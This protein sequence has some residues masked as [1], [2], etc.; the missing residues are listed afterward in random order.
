V[1][2][3]VCHF[4]QGTAAF[5]HASDKTMPED[6]NSGI[7][8]AA[9]KAGV[10]YNPLN[11]AGEKRFLHWRHVPDKNLSALAR[12]TLMLQVLHDGMSH[13]ARH[14]Q[15]IDAAWFTAA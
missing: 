6:V 15:D 5:E 2:Q 11:Q 8:H 10:K 7:G 1:S 13:R 9:A 12:R 3:H 14:R 4:L